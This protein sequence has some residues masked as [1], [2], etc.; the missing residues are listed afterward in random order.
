ME[1]IKNFFLKKNDN[2]KTRLRILRVFLI[3]LVSVILIKSIATV[4]INK[5]GRDM[6]IGSDEEYLKTVNPVDENSPN[7]IVIL[8]DDMGLGDL[9]IYGQ[10]AISTPNIDALAENGMLATNYYTPSPISSPSRAGLLTGRYPTRSLSP[11]VFMDTDTAFSPTGILMKLI[12]GYS[13]GVDGIPEDEILLSEV[14]QQ[15]E[16]ETALFGKW[17]LGIGEGQRPNDNGFDLFYGAL[18][19]NDMNPYRIYEN[20]VVVYDDPVD[21]SNLTKIL[22]EQIVT[23]IDDNK[24]QPFFIYYSSPFPHY[25]A[26][27]SDDFV[28]TSEAGEYGDCVQEIDWSVGEIMK[29]LEDNNLTENTIVVFT[30]D[31]GPW[32]EGDTNGARGRKGQSL[33]GGQRVPFIVSMPGTVEAG[34]ISNELISG[35]DIFPTM[36]DLVGIDLPTDRIIDGIS[37]LDF[38]KGGEDSGRDIYFLQNVKETTAVISDNFKYID[39]TKSDM[40]SYSYVNMGPYLFDLSIDERESYDVKKHY[41]EKAEEMK[42]ELETFRKEMDTNLRG[43]ID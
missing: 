19:S 42:V 41:P 40:S 38:L 34:R 17:H 39:K 11:N 15:A 16:Y 6:R 31:N 9:S 8:V 29:T 21:Q 18:Y 28:N 26:I 14:L 3:I 5:K 43:W 33:D 30:S 25:P 20:D 35:L 22:T 36:L 24:E 32:F 1:K 4:F 10:D 2:N 7:I 13:Y 23:Y 37:V 27:A 12:G